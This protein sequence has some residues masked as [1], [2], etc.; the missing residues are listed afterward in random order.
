MV[1]MA[2]TFSLVSATN[3]L[4]NAP[5]LLPPEGGHKHTPEGDTQTLIMK[6]L[7][8]LG[9]IVLLSVVVWVAVQALSLAP[10]FLS[11][12]GAS[13]TNFTSRL[14]P[15]Q[16]ETLS[17]TLESSNV[18]N[19]EAF[20]FAWHDSQEG[21]TTYALSYE[22]ADSLTLSLE[23]KEGVVIRPM[24]GEPKTFTTATRT[25]TVIPKSPEN[26]FLDASIKLDRIE[27]GKIE[28]TDTVL[29]TIVNEK[30]EMNRTPTTTPATSP[31]TPT[32]STGSGS[33]VIKYPPTYV[34]VPVVS[35]PN[36][37]VDLEVTLIAVGIL[38]NGIVVPSKNIL[39]QDKRGGVT[40]LVTNRGTKTSPAFTFEAKLP[41]RPATTFEPKA[42]DRKELLPG[43]S[44][45]YT[46][47]FNRITNKETGVISIVVDPDRD[48]VESNRLNNSLTIDVTIVED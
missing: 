48:I 45:E 17:I 12:L 46:L 14:F 20:T 5:I 10:S 9:L 36:G 34:T 29:I 11:G 1:G 26:R 2:I 35:D 3:N 43:A 28:A 19:D 4:M 33:E 37:Y 39:N 23:T 22:C 6:S 30:V 27:A 16:T 42:A 24:C 41:T 18:K 31:K 15:A 44:I 21:E 47:G 7:A 8:A 25:I 13:V 38:E 40:F 32:T